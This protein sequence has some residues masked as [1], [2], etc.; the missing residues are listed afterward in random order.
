MN[1]PVPKMEKLSR[2]RL[3]EEQLVTLRT[4]RRSYGIGARLLF[5]LM[6]VAYGPAG[7]FSKYR[8][9][10]LIARVPYQTWEHVA[11]VAITHIARRPDFARRIYQ[12]VREARDQQDNEMYHLLIFEELNHRD[13]PTEPFF[14]YR[15]L[16]QI[17]AFGYYQ[18][19]WILYV[20]K[21]NWSYRLNADFEDHAEHEYMQ[22]VADHPELE[23]VEHDS[24]FEEEYGRFASVAD[25]M[26]Q[27][28]YDE[29]I[30]KLESEAQMAKARFS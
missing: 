27:I 9:L 7:T 29:R 25:L 30:H 2:A 6:D 1:D 14:R 13:R 28:G 3:R 12:R 23:D 17:V 21:P 24:M 10:E 4:P 16:P 19:S 15:V 20:I 18:L 8:V 26:R 11:Y 5:G 22:F